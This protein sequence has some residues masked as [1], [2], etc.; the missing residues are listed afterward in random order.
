MLSRFG[1]ETCRPVST[2]MRQLEVTSRGRKEREET[3]YTLAESGKGQIPNRLY[4]EAIGSLLYLAN[5]TRPDISYAVNVLSRHQVNPTVQEW[6]MVKRVFQY[7][8]GTRNHELIY[9]RTD[10]G[11][12][13]YSDAS[14][15]DCKNSLTT[16]GYVIRLFGN[17]VAWRT[18]KQQSVALSTC[19]SEYVAMSETCQESMSLHNSVAIMLERNLYPLTLYCDNMAAISCAKVNGGNRLRH[20]VERRE[21]YVKECVNKNYIKIEWVNS[22]SQLADIFTKALPKQLHNDLLKYIFNM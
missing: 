16:C 4:R 12:I 13:A 7:L 2:P 8:S 14:L 1:F 18:H 17:T 6:N 15:A 3:D 9:N 20:M 11:L 10:E 21:H 19:Q 5:A 22:K